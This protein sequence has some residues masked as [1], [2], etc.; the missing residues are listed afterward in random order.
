MRN[1]R[2]Q[3]EELKVREFNKKLAKEE[4]W[5]RQGIK[6]RRTRNEGRVRALKKLRCKKDQISIQSKP[7]LT[8]T[9]QDVR[10][11]VIEAEN[12]TLELPNK[13]H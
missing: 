6:A 1:K 8:T 4:T 11:T 2:W 12:L 13:N 3:D 7:S 10:K 5:I 9:K